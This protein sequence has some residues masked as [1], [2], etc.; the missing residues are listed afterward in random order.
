[1][2]LRAHRKKKTL[3]GL[4]RKAVL[5]LIFK[6][7]EIHSQEGQ[8]GHGGVPKNSCLLAYFLPASFSAFFI[9]VPLSYPKVCLS[10]SCRERHLFQSSRFSSPLASPVGLVDRQ[11]GNL[12]LSGCGP[13]ILTSAIDSR[14]SW[15][16]QITLGFI[17]APGTVRMVACREVTLLQ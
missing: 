11:A 8:T 7:V 5:L 12:D 16:S 10:W 15:T 9:P 13:E 17:L 1:M 4:G 14:S 6:I 2:E 3:K